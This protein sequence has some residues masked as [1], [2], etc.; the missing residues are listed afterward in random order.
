MNEDK[1]THGFSISHSL[2]TPHKFPNNDIGIK[3]NVFRGIKDNLYPTGRAFY[4]PIGGN[5]DLFKNAI[6]NV[7]SSFLLDVDL[8]FDSVFPDNENFD[9]RDADLWEY[10]LGMTQI[11]GLTIEERRVNILLKL[12]YPNNVDSRTNSSFIESQ[13]QA[14]GFDLYIHENVYPYIDPSDVAN[15]SLDQNKHSDNLLHGQSS[16]H[17]GG[18][19]QVIANKIDSNEQFSIGSSENLYSTFFI[20]GPN[21]GDFATVDSNRESELREI[22]IKLKPLHTT[23][24]IF[25][26]FI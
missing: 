16:L 15:L 3:S 1:T 22:V 4:A 7:F 9:S 8:F 19:F 24:F 14:A 2:D 20:G 13:L 10:Q 11:T 17:G 18:N 6:I 23:A 5:F 12:G 25:I 21:L 26:N